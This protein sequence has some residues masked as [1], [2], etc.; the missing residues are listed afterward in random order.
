MA[1]AEVEIDAERL[2]EKIMHI[3]QRRACLTHPSLYFPSRRV[4]RHVLTQ[5]LNSTYPH[6]L[7]VK[8]MAYEAEIGSLISPNQ[9]L[10]DY[11]V[12]DL[13]GIILNE[14]NFGICHPDTFFCAESIF[15][16]NHI[17]RIQRRFKF[18]APNP[19]SPEE[20]EEW[21]EYLGVPKTRAAS[22]PDRSLFLLIRSQK[23]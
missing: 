1:N 14:R 15:F 10:I 5:T 6:P 21:K 11:K 22:R 4:Y 8:Q 3:E 13:F 20:V 7:S 23:V 2:A 16:S 9:A 18:N 19:L 17:G 12:K